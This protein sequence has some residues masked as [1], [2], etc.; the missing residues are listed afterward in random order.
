MKDDL[1]ANVVTVV[2]LLAKSADASRL[3]PIQADVLKKNIEVLI[4]HDEDETVRK[5]LAAIRDAKSVLSPN[6]QERLAGYP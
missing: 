1:I 6:L 2:Q 4:E 3:S 5:L